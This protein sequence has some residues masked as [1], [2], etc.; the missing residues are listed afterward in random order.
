MPS[1]ACLRSTGFK[2]NEALPTMVLFGG[3]WLLWKEDFVDPFDFTI[4][5]KSAWFLACNNSFLIPNLLLTVV[6][7]YAPA[8]SK[9]KNEFC[10]E[11]INYVSSIF[12]P[13][14]ILGDFN[15][16]SSSSDIMV[17]ASF[18]Y[19]RRCINAFLNW[20]NCI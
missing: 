3:I 6:F 13:F 16:I 11:I 1:T 8:R 18:N 14:I 10:N 7:I 12:L 19:S 20:L 9:Y 2:S 4:V 5:Y 15:E 17:G